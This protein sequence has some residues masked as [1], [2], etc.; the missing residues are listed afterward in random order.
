[1][2]YLFFYVWKSLWLIFLFVKLLKDRNLYVC[3]INAKKHSWI[4]VHVI[5]ELKYN[6]IEDFME[7]IFKMTADYFKLLNHTEEN[8]T[9]AQ[10]RLIGIL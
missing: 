10:R 5:S 2:S 6:W 1:M 4:F 3:Q 8:L 7:I 9:G